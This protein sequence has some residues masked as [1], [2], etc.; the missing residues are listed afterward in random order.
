M[1]KKA[2]G[3]NLR[4][5]DLTAVAAEKIFDWKSVH[6]HGDKLIGKKQDKAGRWRTATVPAY[7]TNPVHAYVIDERMNRLGLRRRYDRELSR[8][9]KARDLP[10]DWAT[11][12][13]RIRAAVRA[14]EK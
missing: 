14:M 9:T 6:R 2:P 4:D 8:L 1:S 5:A 11:P 7:A 12:G 13:Q 3:R 10:R